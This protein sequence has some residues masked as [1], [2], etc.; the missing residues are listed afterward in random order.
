[1][2]TIPPELHYEVYEHLPLEDLPNYRLVSKSF[3]TIGATRLFRQ[4]IFH[5]SYHSFDRILAVAS[6]PLFRKH[7]QTLLWEDNRWATKSWEEYMQA[8]EGNDWKQAIKEHV[9]KQ[10][11][12]AQRVARH[13]YQEKIEFEVSRRCFT[14]CRN[15]RLKTS[16]SSEE[17]QGDYLRGVLGRFDN[18]EEIRII[19]G[20]FSLHNGKITKNWGEKGK[21]LQPSTSRGRFTTRG[22]GMYCKPYSGRPG[23]EALKESALACGDRLKSLSINHLS[24]SSFSWPFKG[25]GPFYMSITNLRL[26][27]STWEGGMQWGDDLEEDLYDDYYGPKFR[28]IR[29]SIT[30]LGLLKVFIG[31]FQKLEELSLSITPGTEVCLSDV[32]SDNLVSIRSL[33]FNSFDTEEQFFISLLLNKADKLDYLELG[34]INLQPPGS[35]LRIFDAIQGRMSLRSAAFRGRLLDGDATSPQDGWNMDE[36]HLAMKLEEC[37][38][39]GGV[40]PLQPDEQ[41]NVLEGEMDEVAE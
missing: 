24:L 14:Y 40:C 41:A 19:N 29:P 33:T 8:R 13:H 36:Y 39:K 2:E 4:L 12:P 22:D 11:D 20:D 5:P 18:L 15:T 23:Q 17:V 16:W 30:N 6:H 37:L 35:W 38:I 21:P 10:L 1:M 32:L 34:N 28:A 26:V 25:P 7:V 31:H 9:I 27:I 3:A